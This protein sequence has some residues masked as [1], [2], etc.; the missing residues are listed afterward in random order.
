MSGRALDLLGGLGLILLGMKLMT[1]GLKLAGGSLLRK[2]LKHW[3]RTPLR[4]LGV[5]L[6]FTSM[7]QSSSA[8]TVAAIG[9]VNAGMMSLARAVWV[10]YGSNIGTTSTAWIVAFVG[11]K[12]DI[13]GLALP[14]IAV[15]TAMWMFGRVSRR[16]SLGE[17][18]A[19][20][21]LFFL[22]VKMLQGSLGGIGPGLAAMDFPMQG[23]AG[24]AAFL[25]V[26]FAL[27]AVMQSSSAAVALL[28]TA[29]SA[30]AVPVETSAAAVIGANLGTTSTAVLASIG[31]TPNAKRAAAVHVTFNL[32]TGAAAFLLLGPIVGPLDRLGLNTASTLAL[33]HTIF[34][35]LG[36]VI[37]WPVTGRLVAFM[38]HRFRTPLEEES[39]PRCLDGNIIRTPGLAVGAL[40]REVGRLSAISRRMALAALD[41]GDG[42]GQTA[43]RNAV[44]DK[45]VFDKLLRGIG[46]YAAG[47]SAE[48]LPKDVSEVLPRIM[49]AAQYFNAAA[50]TALD[51]EGLQSGLT[52]FDDSELYKMLEQSHVMAA[53]L[54]RRCDPE[55]K[56]FSRTMLRELT[57]DYRRVYES[58]KR[59][60]LS[61][62]PAGVLPVEQMVLRLDLESR[63]RRMVEQLTKGALLLSNLA[64]S[65]DVYDNGLAE[66]DGNGAAAETEAA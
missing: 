49:R 24:Q 48:G 55:H 1:D 7:V 2:S 16:S 34:N 65:W 9:F 19:G 12:V 27:T 58:Q 52:P 41:C 42:T 36:V 5:G 18:L 62:G 14:L 23:L 43:G 56:T 13:K 45:A 10:I 20:F 15:G 21:G 32:I 35:V 8:V 60:I 37:L 38:K 6:A 17:A 29:A 54:V 51:A 25:A 3:T 57:D 22:G 66:D 11:L 44:E 26:G 63:N 59:R 47:I 40:M 64:G 28:L 61:A 50:E 53:A 31:A 30:N 39:K 4:G 46:K 33:F